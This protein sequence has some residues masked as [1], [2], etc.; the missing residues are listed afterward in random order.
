MINKKLFFHVI[1]LYSFKK[2]SFCSFVI[3]KIKIYSTLKDEIRGDFRI[4][5]LLMPLKY[6]KNYFV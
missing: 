1:M 5:V 3:V 4:T 6:N 2:G